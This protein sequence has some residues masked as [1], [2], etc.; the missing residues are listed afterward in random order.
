MLDDD[1]IQ[2]NNPIEREREIIFNIA[3]FVSDYW[4]I[5]IA[6]FITLF[7]TIAGFTLALS[8][9]NF[10]KLAKIL[11]LLIW[12]LLAF[13][14]IFIQ[15]RLHKERGLISNYK[16]INEI[17]RTKLELQES[18]NYQFWSDVCY[19]IS[20]AIGFGD[21]ARIS[22]Y[23]NQNGI[24][25]MLGRYS[26][27]PHNN[28]KGR[29]NYK[30]DEGCIGRAWRNGSSFYDNLP[31]FAQS[32]EE[33]YRYSEDN[34][35]MSKEII[36]KIKMKSRTIYAK[37]I[38]ENQGKNRSAI[39]VFES[40]KPNSFTQEN[41]DNVFSKYESIICLAIQRFKLYEPNPNFAKKE[42]F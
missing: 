19:C 40:L 6:S 4:K 3:D 31:D 22:L 13:V 11:L 42:G 23:K 16:R 15:V 38:C 9:T 8:N 26:L 12:M 27:N 35:A 34:F 29:M 14:F 24:F 20:Q 41:I 2:E 25:T 28:K 7:Y 21:D 37:A 18:E 1:T 36:S 30:E 10:P 17:I 33:Y 5:I 39:I 32:P